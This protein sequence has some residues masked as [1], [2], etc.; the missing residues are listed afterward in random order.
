MPARLLQKDDRLGSKV[1][2]VQYHI[3]KLRPRKARAQLGFHD[4]QHLWRVRSQSLKHEQGEHGEGASAS[5]RPTSEAA[6]FSGP[7]RLHQARRGRAP[8]VSSP[9]SHAIL[10]HGVREK[11]RWI[12]ASTSLRPCSLQTE[13]S[14]A[15]LGAV[16]LGAECAV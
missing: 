10:G 11:C 8:D 4:G 9:H 15:S 14:G 6:P 5:G 16:C 2:T 12:S 3:S 13:A 7:G 1:H